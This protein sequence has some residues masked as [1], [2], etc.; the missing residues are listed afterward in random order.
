M[1]LGPFQL[2]FKQLH[3][4][5]PTQKNKI[6][7]NV[8]ISHR[9]GSELLLG[10]STLEIPLDDSFFLEIKMALKDA[11]GNWKEN[12]FMHKIPK[13]CSSFKKTMGKNW[14]AFINGIGFKTTDCPIPS[15][16][17][18]AQGFN[19][20]LFMDT[21][22]PKV[23]IYGTYRVHMYYSRKNEIFG[24]IVCIVEFKRP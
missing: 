11:S 18:I 14:P 9:S 21:N 13:A 8:Y 24:C 6:Q 12:S 17:Y 1:K 16:T 10:N 20:S 7:H 4:C 15:G 5:N 23:F 2:I 19:M 22:F 3:N